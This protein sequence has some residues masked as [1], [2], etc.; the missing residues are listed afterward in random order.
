MEY[1][2]ETQRLTRCFGAREVVSS[3]NLK[4]PKGC[5][6]GF[7][8]RNG[9]GKSTTIRMLLG[10]LEPTRGSATVLGED[11]Q[12]LR[13][14]I[15]G[16]IGYQ[17]EGHQVYGWMSVK[18]LRDFQKGTFGRWNDDVFEG[19]IRHFDLKPKDKAKNLSRGQRAGLCLG[20]T[21]A[22][23]PEL[24]ILDD[25]ALGLDAVARRSL[26]QAMVYVTRQG[27]QSILFSSH[28]LSDVGRVADRIAVLDGGILRAECALDTFRDRIRQVAMTFDDMPQTLPALPGLLQ[29]SRT[30]SEIVLTFANYDERAASAL[31]ALGPR[32]MAETTLGFEDAFIAYT[33]ARGEQSFLLGGKESTS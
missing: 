21:L 11:C 33:S 24:P 4:I 5:I 13:P 32:S 23:E 18:E 12:K 17:A 19:V 28:M 2:I 22:P 8:G 7:L 14:E 10:L 16:R 6:Y 26:L 30:G 9:A 27:D 1:V 29:T 31:S 3:L 15:R 20:L 25:P